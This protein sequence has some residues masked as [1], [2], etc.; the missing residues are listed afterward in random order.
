MPNADVCFSNVRVWSMDLIVFSVS[1]V[2]TF[3]GVSSRDSGKRGK[4][5]L[6][7]KI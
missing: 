6:K 2:K 4:K 7:Q 1:E 5:N 3:D